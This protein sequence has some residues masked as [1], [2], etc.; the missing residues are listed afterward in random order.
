[1]KTDFVLYK[2]NSKHPIVVNETT[3]T[4]LLKKCQDC[5]YHKLDINY[6]TNR[7]RLSKL[8]IKSF[9]VEKQKTDFLFIHI[10][11]T[12]G[13][14]FKFNV[15]YNPHL[16]KKIS[17]YHKVRYPPKPEPDLNIFEQKKKMFTLLRD[18]E[19]TVISA[20]YHFKHILNISL[21]E[22]CAKYRNMQ[23]KFLLGYDIFSQVKV[24]KKDVENIIKLIEEKKLI[25][26]IHQTKKMN[27]IYELLE[28][29]ADKVDN[30]VW[31]KKKY[32]S[33]KPSAIS[34]GLKQQLKKAN[35]LDR[36]LFSYVRDS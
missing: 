15:I 2:E 25:V 35:Y 11:K 28:L 8:G 17:I 20:Y 36:L 22:F 12:G 33:Y 4:S 31:N 16:T 13:I 18:P 26:G 3:N 29:P 7:T 34:K 6:F 27:D 1:M 23:V 10:P 14:S 32:I 30:Y 21:E 5:W 19:S 9:G 24:S